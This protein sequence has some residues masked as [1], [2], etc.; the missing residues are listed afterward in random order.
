VYCSLCSFLF[1]YHVHEK[2]ILMT[3]IPMAII[4]AKAR[5]G[6]RMA[7]LYMFLT[8][9]GTYSLFPLLT[10]PQE[11]LIKVFLLLTY[12]I[13]AVP[14]LMREGVL[15]RTAGHSKLE[16]IYLM[17]IV[18]VELYCSFGHGMVFKDRWPFI[19]LMLI[20][21]YS[22]IGIVYAWGVMGMSYIGTGQHREKIK[23]K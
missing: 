5:H 1:G 15:S 6:D 12:L 22:A 17:G 7:G 20:S 13:I 11:Y 4:V 16:K 21:V 19:P 23:I 2:A 3:L 10:E 9:I 14:W 8:T 18:P